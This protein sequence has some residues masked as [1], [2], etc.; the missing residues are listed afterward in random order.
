MKHCSDSI[1]IRENQF[2]NGKPK[3]DP[4]W[5]TEYLEKLGLDPRNP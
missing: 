5:W 2:P 3:K 1:L 4:D